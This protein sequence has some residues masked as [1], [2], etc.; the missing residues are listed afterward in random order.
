MQVYDVPDA[1]NPE[2]PTDA[3]RFLNGMYTICTLG[4]YIFIGKYDLDEVTRAAIHAPTSKNWLME[5]NY[6]FQTAAGEGNI[7][8]DPSEWTYAIT[9]C[10]L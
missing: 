7:F 10:R 8:G 1:L 4:Y 5:F 6:P 9:F 3:S 2:A